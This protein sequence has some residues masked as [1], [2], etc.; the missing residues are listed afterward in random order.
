MIFKYKQPNGIRTRPLRL[1]IRNPSTLARAHSPPRNRWI[2]FSISEFA[3]K[4]TLGWLPV[5]PQC[6]I[7][8]VGVL[9]SKTQR[10]PNQSVAC[11]PLCRQLLVG[12]LGSKTQ[13]S[14]NQSVACLPLFRQLVVSCLQEARSH[15]ESKA[16]DVVQCSALGVPRMW[17]TVRGSDSGGAYGLPRGLW[18]ESSCNLASHQRSPAKEAV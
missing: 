1:R 15:L 5:F 9:G 10:S 14:P 3:R 4:L 17:G 7:L 8:A 11:L 16:V 12:V 2:F 13:R 6:S 18:M